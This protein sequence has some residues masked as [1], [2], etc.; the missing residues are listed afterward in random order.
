VSG[1]RSRALPRV[2]DPVTVH[3]LGRRAA[4]VIEDVLD[5]GRRVVVS[6]EDDGELHVFELSPATARF[7]E[8]GRQAGARLT[9]G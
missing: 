9:F 3:Q 8:G 2:G 6:T 4:G 7:V 1:A 5:G